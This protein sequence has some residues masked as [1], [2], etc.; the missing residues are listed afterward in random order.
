MKRVLTEEDLKEHPEMMDQGFE[1]GDE[2]EE[3][4]VSEQAAKESGDIMVSIDK[5]ALEEN[6]RVRLTIT[7]QTDG[8][9]IIHTKVAEGLELTA[10]ELIGLIEV[11]KSDLLNNI[12]KN[13]NDRPAPPMPEFSKEDMEP[14]KIKLTEDDLKNFP[15]LETKMNFK[16]DQEIEL[17]KFTVEM[18]MD[19]R[20]P[21]EE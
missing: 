11:A 8:S 18:L 16:V 6:D 17:P 5:V 1:V 2:V 19:A 4:N 14:T 20:T 12:V 21:T 7:E 10:T 15:E 13:S 3:L 9:L